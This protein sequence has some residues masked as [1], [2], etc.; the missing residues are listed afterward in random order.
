MGYL[1]SGSMAYGEDGTDRM[2]LFFDTA[3]S[4]GRDDYERVVYH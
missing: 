3:S 1:I 2:A 4:Y